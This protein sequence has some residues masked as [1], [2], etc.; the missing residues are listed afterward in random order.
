MKSLGKIEVNGQPEYVYS[1]AIAYYKKSLYIHGGESTIGL[2]MR[3]SVGKNSFL[4]IDFECEDENECDFKCSPGTY[5]SV[6]YGCIPCQEGSFSGESGS[7]TCQKCPAGTF[8]PSKSA[9]SQSQCYPCQYGHFNTYSGAS[10][11]KSCPTG[12]SCPVGS[13][14]PSFNKSDIDVNSSIQP[15]NFDM[16]NEY[17]ENKEL[18]L[19]L[20]IPLFLGLIFLFLAVEKL[21][22]ILSKFDLFAN[23]HNH[24]QD[25]LMY[26]RKT[27]LGV[28]FSCSFTFIAFL[29]IISGILTYNYNNLQEIKLLVPLIT[30]SDLVLNFPT[31]IQ[32]E[33]EL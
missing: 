4:R 23:L 8:G 7:D 14:I 17:S 19:G 3:K 18:F 20:Y 12:W 26:L 11:C 25:S 16:S 1:A 21:R 10:H 32:I 24:K 22:R 27:S 31:D 33:T 28:F 13:T 6:I 29:I 2:A 15:N 30:I 9:N 5:I